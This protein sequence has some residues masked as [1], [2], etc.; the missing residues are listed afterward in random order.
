MSQTAI[1]YGRRKTKTMGIT[2]YR[3]PPTRCPRLLRRAPFVGSVRRRQRRQDE[4]G[5]TKAGDKKTDEIDTFI[6]RHLLKE[7]SAGKWLCDLS[8]MSKIMSD[9]EWRQDVSAE[10]RMA[11][12]DRRNTTRRERCT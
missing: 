9:V 4:G 12:G 3:L 7:F 5:T 6:Y 11:K 2:N 10:A 1:D 8:K